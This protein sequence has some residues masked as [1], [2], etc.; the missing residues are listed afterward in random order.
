MIEEMSI[1]KTEEMEAGEMIEDM[2]H[3]DPEITLP[4]GEGE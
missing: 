3:M 4:K 2:I 1:G